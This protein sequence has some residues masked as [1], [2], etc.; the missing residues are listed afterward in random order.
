MNTEYRLESLTIR[1]NDWGEFKG[2]HTGK[3]TF[4]NKEA[5]GFM[6]NLSSDETEQFIKLLEPK[7]IASAT[8]LGKKLLSS[9]NM[10]P[11][12]STPSS[13]YIDH[14]SIKPQTTI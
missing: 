1:F 10:L 3:I 12:P 5:E 11:P 13:E 8:N 9:L 4:Q 2:R 7:L 14:E 6:F